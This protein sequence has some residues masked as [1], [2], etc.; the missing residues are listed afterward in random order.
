VKVKDF[1]EE[2]FWAVECPK[3]EEMIDMNELPE[4]GDVI[5]CEQCLT[6]IKV[7]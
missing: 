3:C 4:D 5:F 6:N 2:R 7:G 1:T